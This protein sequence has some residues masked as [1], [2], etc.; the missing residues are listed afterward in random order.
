MYTAFN[1]WYQ[2]Y[3][4]VWSVLRMVWSSDSAAL[5]V[6]SAWLCTTKIHRDP[7]ITCNGPE[8]S[9]RKA[10]ISE[11]GQNKGV[12]QNLRFADFWKSLYSS[13]KCIHS[14]GSALSQEC[15]VS[16]ALK[17]QTCAQS[18]WW[19]LCIPEQIAVVWQKS[20]QRLRFKGTEI[21]LLYNYTLVD[22]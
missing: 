13:L 5:D 22:I 3:R 7:A 19:D 6:Q 10:K 21:A 9:T 4:K 8:T 12:L 15:S 16:Q 17:L 14:T 11:I 1:W 20:F 2:W 18:R